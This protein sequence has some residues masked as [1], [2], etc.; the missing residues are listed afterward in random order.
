[1]APPAREQVCVAIGTEGAVARAGL[2]A[3]RSL[4]LAFRANDTYEQRTAEILIASDEELQRKHARVLGRYAY[5]I[6]AV[7]KI[8]H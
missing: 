4:I 6:P 1:M 3:P 7:S 5:P 2:T 8:L